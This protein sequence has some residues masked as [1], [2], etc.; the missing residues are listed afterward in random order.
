MAT[1]VHC[2]GSSKHV[3]QTAAT[4]KMD[5]LGQRPRR[6]GAAGATA[7][8]KSCMGVRVYGF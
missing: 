5:G 3:I 7:S 8:G 1:S 2:T 6:T 4:T